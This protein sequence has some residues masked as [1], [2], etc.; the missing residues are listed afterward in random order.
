MFWMQVADT[1]AGETLSMPEQQRAAD[2]LRNQQ[3]R[4]AEILCKQPRSASHKEQA[5]KWP[6]IALP[7]RLVPLQ[8]CPH[9]VTLALYNHTRCPDAYEE[10]VY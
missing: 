5:P 2:G 10:G 6:F 1:L 9:S 3:V 8:F 7:S 4:E